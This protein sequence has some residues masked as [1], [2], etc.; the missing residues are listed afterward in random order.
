MTETYENLY[1]A[2][3]D[4]KFHERTCNYW[5]LVQTST[6]SHTAFHNR[7]NLL[8]W[9]K[10][11]GLTLTEPLA[12]HGTSSWQAVNGSYRTQ[13]HSD[14]EEFYGQQGI[15]SRTLSNGDWT[16]AIITTDA[17]STKTV[18][19]LNPN[20]KNRHVFDYEASRQLFG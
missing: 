6:L 1:V 13:S 3:L 8:T 11:R 16:L 10:E 14:Y 20:C 5:Y 17:D 4:Q 18:H 19:T 2:T 9:L 15:T 7:D 12:E